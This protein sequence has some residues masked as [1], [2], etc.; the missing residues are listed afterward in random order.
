MVEVP[1]GAQ[2]Q[3]QLEWLTE[4]IAEPVGRACCGAPSCGDF[5][6]GGSWQTCA[7]RDTLSTRKPAACQGLAV[8]ELHRALRPCSKS[9]NVDALLER[10]RAF[11]GD[12]GT[13]GDS[14]SGYWPGLT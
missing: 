9:T 7:V 1:C 10:D 6:S 11:S 2:T 5:S 12:A 13:F 3:E 4:E 8:G 14:R